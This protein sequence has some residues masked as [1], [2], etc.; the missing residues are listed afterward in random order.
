MQATKLRL[1]EVKSHPSVTQL[2]GNRVGPGLSAFLPCRGEGCGKLTLLTP[3]LPGQMGVGLGSEPPWPG[4]Q[5][6][7][8]GLQPAPDCAHAVPAVL[9]GPES[10]GVL[11]RMSD[12]LELMV[13]RMDMLA[14]LGNSSEPHRAAGDTHF[15][16]DR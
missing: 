6:A 9:G 4:D 16:V 11:R 1:K 2:V 12:L 14:R 10:R 13:K 15:A 5:A 7:S 3:P 8:G